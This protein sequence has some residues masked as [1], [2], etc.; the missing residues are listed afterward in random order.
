VVEQE[1]DDVRGLRHG[2]ESGV[3][4]WVREVTTE[5]SRRRVNWQ[6]AMV[7]TGLVEPEYHRQNADDSGWMLY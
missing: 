2:E 4:F 3:V 6:V 1:V 7:M 5:G